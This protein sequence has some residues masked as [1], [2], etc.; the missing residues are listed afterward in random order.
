MTETQEP[1]Q[2]PTPAFIGASWIALLLGLTAYL[3]GLWNAQMQLNEKGT[4]SP[5]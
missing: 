4:T 2:K 1:P 3:V 5:C